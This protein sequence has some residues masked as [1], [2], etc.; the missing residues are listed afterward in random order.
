M[1]YFR[2]SRA[3]RSRLRRFKGLHVDRV[4][5]KSCNHLAST[6]SAD[7]TTCKHLASA[8]A[9]ATTSHRGDFRL[10][11][12]QLLTTLAS[13]FLLVT[14]HISTPI[15]LGEASTQR[16]LISPLLEDSNISP[17]LLQHL[18]AS[19]LPLQFLLSSYTSS[20]PGAEFSCICGRGFNS[21]SH[22]SR[23][24][25]SC[26]VQNEETKQAYTRAVRRGGSGKRK[27]RRSNEDD[28]HNRGDIEAG[29]STSTRKGAVGS[30]ERRV[31]SPNVSL[32]I[33]IALMVLYKGLTYHAE[34]GIR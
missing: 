16:H 6:L 34:D 20:M 4:I 12:W 13:I 25:K 26:A 30:S 17:L 27:R 10:R 32:L 18:S 21:E 5:G 33:Y 29:P 22:Y 11:F 9:P 24:E 19:Q 15:G 23:H 2:S 7:S 8:M 28:D 14:C 31:P 1:Q 3:A